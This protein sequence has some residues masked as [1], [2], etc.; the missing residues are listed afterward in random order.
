MELL[1]NIDVPNLDKGIQFY[2][3]AFGWKVKQRLG[4]WGVELSGPS[5]RVCL[6]QN[7]EESLAA[8]GICQEKRHYERHWTPVHVDISVREIKR[9]VRKALQ[10]GAE[11]EGTVVNE[12]YGLLAYL[13]DPFGNGFCLIQFNRRGYKAI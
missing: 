10:A 2:K 9:A 3:K 7:P 12:P 6:I 4:D 13:S 5:S 1:L 11:Q 8:P